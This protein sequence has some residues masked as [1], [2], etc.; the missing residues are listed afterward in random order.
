MQLRIEMH[1][2]KRVSGFFQTPAC[3]ASRELRH[4][5]GDYGASMK[6]SLAGNALPHHGG[7]NNAAPGAMLAAGV[8]YVMTLNNLLFKNS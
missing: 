3:V 2:K 1:I 4:A 8:L 6:R 5:S 7:A